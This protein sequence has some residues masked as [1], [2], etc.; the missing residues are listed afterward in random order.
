MGIAVIDVFERVDKAYRDSVRQPGQ[1]I[2]E[3]VR[4]RPT[5][6]LEQRRQSR[7]FPGGDEPE[8]AISGRAEDQIA[9][10][11]Q[12]EGGG[13]L[14]GFDCRYVAADQNHRTA[15]SAG[16][17]AAHAAAEIAAALRKDLVPRRQ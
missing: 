5:H 9:F 8:P 10:S 6:P 2:G 15:R 17:G 16:D 3:S 4:A 14:A 1:R 7:P 12:P 11:E 13:D